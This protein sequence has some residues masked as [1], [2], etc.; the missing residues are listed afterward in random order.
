[1]R[2]KEKK[3]ERSKGKKD[4]LIWHGLNLSA[5]SQQKKKKKVTLTLTAPCPH[6][7]GI[8]IIARRA[9]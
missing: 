5:S 7:T 3:R 8:K 1:M 2:T 6:S 9:V 4:S